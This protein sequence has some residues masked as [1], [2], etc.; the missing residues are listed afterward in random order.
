MYANSH[1]ELL[2]M[3]TSMRLSDII[4]LYGDLDPV[5]HL[6]DLKH[7]AEEYVRENCLTAL[8]IPWDDIIDDYSAEEE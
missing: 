8:G 3:F 1:Q 4:D 7:W 5:P 2:S 6:R